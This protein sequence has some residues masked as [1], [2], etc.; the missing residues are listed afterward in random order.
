M[1]QRVVEEV[2]YN[3]TPGIGDERAHFRLDAHRELYTSG[4]HYQGFNEVKML[5]G[6]ILRLGGLCN[7]GRISGDVRPGIVKAKC[8]EVKKFIS[9][10]NLHF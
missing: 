2:D 8:S 3:N 4:L 10:I 5:I 9:M 1:L 6:E 7:A